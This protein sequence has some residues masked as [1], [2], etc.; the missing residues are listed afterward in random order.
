MKLLRLA[1]ETTKFPFMRFRRVSYPFSALLSILS[2]TLFLTLGV[3]FGIDFSGGTLIELRAKSGVADL[4]QL[5]AEAHALNLGDV[6]VQGFGQ[7]SDVTFRFGVQHGPLGE[8]AEQQAA[9]SRVRAALG[10]AYEIRRI[11]VVGPRVSNELV[12][13]GT[14]G[15]VV[16]IVAVL[17]YLWFRFEWQFAVA[18]IIATMHDLLLTVGFFSLTR[19]EFN[20]TSIAAIL[21]I[22]GYSLNETVVVLDRIREMMRKYRRMPTDELIDMS[23]NAVLPR[24]IMTATT[25]ILA[26]LSLV[27]FGGQVIRS[28]SLAMLFGVFVCTYSAV[29]I[30]SPML[31]YL[32]LRNETVGA[33]P[34]AGKLASE[35]A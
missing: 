24:T 15:V 19:L 10:D 32:G 20:T 17:C 21:T 31:I 3:N 6:E 18:A 11:E 9:V 7:P 23:I 33:D 16:A 25:V 34:G 1:P 29:F 14:L 26:L 30:C 4:A 22:V 28:F 35:S 12:Q 8:A 27:I 2:V 5:R 13:S